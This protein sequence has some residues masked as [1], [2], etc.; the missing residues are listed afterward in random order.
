[1][2]R[3]IKCSPI[4]IV[5]CSLLMALHADAQV[6]RRG[7]LPRQNPNTGGA[8]QR[9]VNNS[10]RSNNDTLKHRTGLEDSITIFYRYLDSSR[11]IGF[12][13]SIYDFRKKLPVPATFYNLGNL[14]TAANNY[15][16]DPFLKAGWDPGFHVLDVYKFKLEDTRFYNT[17]RPYSE[18]GYLLGSKSEQMIHLLHSQN[19]KPNWNV[20]FQ[21]RLINSPGFVQNL[22]TNHN[23]YRFN[24][25]YQSPNKR[26]SNFFV[27]VANTLQSSENGGIKNDRLGGVCVAVCAAA[28]TPA[29]TRKP[30]TRTRRIMRILQPSF[31]EAS[32]GKSAY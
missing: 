12:D 23:N 20:A 32:E 14:G 29:M 11:L 25:W 1:M 30:R 3:L 16:F 21:Y 22:N 8:N 6:G 27:V 13:S 28:A 31:A 19:I 9:G 26:Y 4:L 7:N 24:S 2:T 5:F 15:L 17:T 10:A 18:I